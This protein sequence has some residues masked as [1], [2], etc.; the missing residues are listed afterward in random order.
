MVYRGH[1]ID[2]K[3]AASVPKNILGPGMP[4][5]PGGFPRP[6]ALELVRDRAA[7]H[8]RKPIGSRSVS[9]Q[10]AE[11]YLQISRR[12]VLPRQSLREERLVQW[13]ASSHP[14]GF[15]YFADAR[16]RILAHLKE[17][18][19][20]VAASWSAAALL[21]IP[22]F[23][24]DADS[25]VINGSDARGPLDPLCPG[26]LRH[27]IDFQPWIYY[28]DQQPIEVSP[29]ML[30]L[31]Q[32][33]RSTLRRQHRWQVPVIPG[34][35]DSEVRSVQVIDRFR[36]ELGVTAAEVHTACATLID[37]R[38][39]R[40]LLLLSDPGADSPPETSLR[41]VIAPVV[42]ET[43]GILL[44]Q[45]PILRD[46]SMG[47]SLSRH[48]RRELLTIIDNA[49]ITHRIAFYY[50]GEHH[51]ERS[52]RDRDAL[53]TAELIRLG[54]LPFRVSAGML[55]TPVKLRQQ[56]RELISSRI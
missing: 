15:R 25:W 52:R 49:D 23:S 30:T 8:L 48:P 42:R 10:L 43:G 7:R 3:L 4:L 11:W 26:R 13:G 2:N 14:R 22:D 21:G 51:L 6:E 12:H 41:L 37:R 28:E 54:W 34:L 27:R 16:T 47:E 33:L 1:P 5:P 56:T 44:S 9:R 53:I 24:H 55:A 50:D 35:T 31:V 40:R 38:V 17:K 36:R 19:A 46:G 20:A 29:P 39:V 45:V 18:P 32:C